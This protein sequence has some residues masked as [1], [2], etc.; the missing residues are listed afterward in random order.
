MNNTDFALHL[1]EVINGIISCDSN[2]LDINYLESINNNID[3]SINDRDRLNDIGEN[4]EYLLA[5]KNL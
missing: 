5:A 4:I 2:R 3:N 1:K